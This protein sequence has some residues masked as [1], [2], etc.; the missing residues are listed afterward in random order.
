MTLKWKPIR[1]PDY[2]YSQA[3]A[4]VFTVVVH[5]RAWL[6]GEVVAQEFRPSMAGEVVKQVW[7]DLPIRFPTIALDA[8]VVM[9]NHIHGIVFLGSKPVSAEEDAIHGETTPRTVVSPFIASLDS[10]RSLKVQRSRKHRLPTPPSRDPI[11]PAL[12]EIV[13]SLKA[14]STTQIRKRVIPTFAWQPKYWDRIV[15]NEAELEKYRTYIENNPARW[16]EDKEFLK[17][18]W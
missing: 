3:N 1:Y 17:G 2:D 5:E 4:Y 7:L 13:R 16:E 18:D 8:F 9:P 10:T 11:T 12:G 6:L 15:R 14:A